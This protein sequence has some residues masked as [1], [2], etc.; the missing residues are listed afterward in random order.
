MLDAMAEWLLARADGAHRNGLMR[1]LSWMH[2][3][4]LDQGCTLDQPC[5]DVDSQQ[6]IAACSSLEFLSLYLPARAADQ[7]RPLGQAE[8]SVI[9]EFS[10]EVLSYRVDPRP[11]SADLF[12]GAV[13][14]EPDAGQ[15][16]YNTFGNAMCGQALLSA[17]A[18]T[19]DAEYLAASEDIGEFLLRMQD[20][21]E[22]YA[23][24]GV[25]P[26]VD[27][28]GK[29]VGPP[30]GFFDQVSSLNNTASTMSLW[31]MTAVDFL[32][33][34][35]ARIPSRGF[36]EG[37][38]AGRAFL[39]EALHVG[40]DWYTVR[41][42]SPATLR[43]RVFASASFRADCQDSHWH[44]KG[45]CTLQNG[46][47]VGGTLGTDMVEYGLAAMYRYDERMH[48]RAAA[49]AA[50]QEHYLRYA[51]LPGV[52]TI[53]PV[54]PL[55]CV[56]DSRSGPVD[57]YS[58]PR[59]LGGAPSLDDWAYDPHLSFGGFFRS[60]GAQLVTSE[61][62]YYDV[63]GFG[64]LAEVREALV[65]QSF[66]HGAERF[67]AAGDLT[68][69]L[70]RD[71]SPMALPGRDANDLDG[72][73]DSSESVC[74]RVEGTLPIAHNGIGLLRTLGYVSAPAARP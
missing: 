55:Q 65:P 28:T 22:Y 3:S 24:F 68:A 1:K 27:A 30:G 74:V 26:F 52:H 48:G 61:S 63:V 21:R 25:H 40:A 15:P 5:L 49:L 43:N 33:S 56:D 10:D 67:L 2:G 39:E 8:Q 53:T 16:A 19:G 35:D 44:R 37:A 62:K 18:A 42:D 41:F 54:D 50:S 58:P 17:Y 60:S 70:Y 31:N 51:E 36:A 73:G 12:D 6:S 46:V 23:P 57:A 20:P 9:A 66:R 72:D 64:V 45:S 47:P 69:L 13:A 7:G 29:P 11:A 59:T 14:I 32:A 34:L 71:L 38:A 4:S